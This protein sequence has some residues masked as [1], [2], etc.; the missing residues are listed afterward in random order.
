LNIQKVGI[1]NLEYIS[2]CYEFAN[3][4]YS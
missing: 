4:F 1:I 2:I 3:S